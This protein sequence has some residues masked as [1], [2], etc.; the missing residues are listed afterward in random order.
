MNYNIL[1]E[2]AFLIAD[3]GFKIF[4]SHIPTPLRPNILQ[5]APFLDASRTHSA[6]KV[7]A[8]DGIIDFKK[9]KF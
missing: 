8:D 3:F 6:A 4:L 7:S 1:S 9:G 5:F 2:F